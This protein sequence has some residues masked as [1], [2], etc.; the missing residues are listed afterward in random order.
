MLEIG[1]Q[2]QRFLVSDQNPEFECD[3]DNMDYRDGH[4]GTRPKVIFLTIAHPFHRVGGSL[5]LFAGKDW[6]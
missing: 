5:S 2:Y 6:I 3:Y 1:N 4:K